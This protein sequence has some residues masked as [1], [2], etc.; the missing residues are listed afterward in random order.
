MQK[1][2][3][4]SPHKIDAAMAACLAWEARCDALA[5]GVGKRK[6]SVYEDRG[7]VAV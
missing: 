6:R 5:S 1:E 2:R 3:S 7:L 4:D